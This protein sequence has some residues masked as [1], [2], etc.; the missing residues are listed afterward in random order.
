MPLNR[1][2]KGLRSADKPGKAV[3]E[4]S[5]PGRNLVATY[6]MSRTVPNHNQ[7]RILDG[8]SPVLGFKYVIDGLSLSVF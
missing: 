6:S 8:L 1:P 2:C 3:K 4:R 7:C 5:E